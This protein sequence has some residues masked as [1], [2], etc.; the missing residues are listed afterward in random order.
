MEVS[1]ED[2]DTCYH[3]ETVEYLP[4]G[5]PSITP[6]RVARILPLDPLFVYMV[7]HRATI[8][9]LPPQPNA[10]QHYPTVQPHSHPWRRQTVYSRVQGI[11]PRYHG[12]VAVVRWYHHGRRG[13]WKWHG[14]IVTVV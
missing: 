1:W 11:H 5:S 4:M 6:V 2:R 3:G 7:M 14:N 12:Y 13:P 10:T 9:I 8:D